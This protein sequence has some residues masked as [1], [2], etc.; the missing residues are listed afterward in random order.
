MWIQQHFAAGV[1][2]FSALS[3]SGRAL[4]AQSIETAGARSSFAEAEHLSSRFPVTSSIPEATTLGTLLSEL[5]PTFIVVAIILAVVGADAL[6]RERAH[7]PG[8]A[9]VDQS[10]RHE[11]RQSA[12]TARAPGLHD[13]KSRR[14]QRRWFDRRWA[15]DAGRRSAEPDA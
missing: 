5:S 15:P 10:Q 8:L 1:L 4:A 13:A 12:E 9:Q 3:A 11:A 7:R 14:H 2:A 6:T